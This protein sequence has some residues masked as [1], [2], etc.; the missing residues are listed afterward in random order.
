[1]PISIQ[2]FRL[3]TGIFCSIQHKII[4]KKNTLIQCG[5]QTTRSKMKNNIHFENLTTKSKEPVKGNTASICTYYTSLWCLQIYLFKTKDIFFSQKCTETKNKVI[6]KCNNSQILI[7]PNTFTKQLLN[8][9]QYLLNICSIMLC[10][11]FLCYM[12]LILLLSNDI[13]TNPG[14]NIKNVSTNTTYKHVICGNIHQGSLRYVQRLTS[15]SSCMTNSITSLAFTFLKNVTKWSNLDI[16][17][18]IEHGID[19]YEK[20]YPNRHIKDESSYL[21]VNDLNTS[22]AINKNYFTCNIHSSILGNLEANFQDPNRIFSNLEE[23]LKSSFAVSNKCIFIL[24][25]YGMSVFRSSNSF[26]VFDP[27]S[28]NT[29]GL[30]SENGTAVCTILT[31]FSDLCKHI[32]LLGQSLI[33]KTLQSI[34]FEIT[35]IHLQIRQTPPESFYMLEPSNIH[36]LSNVPTNIKKE[37]TRNPNLLYAQN[38]DIATPSTSSKIPEFISQTKLPQ[39]RKITSTEIPH[40][41][42]SIQ[43]NKRRN[44]QCKN[45]LPE[46]TSELSTKNRSIPNS[47]LT[48]H[49]E[50]PKVQTQNVF[51]NN[52]NIFEKELIDS[53]IDSS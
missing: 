37:N 40:Y 6:T 16:D 34:Q 36:I 42:T 21:Q 2:Q 49:I 44:L 4:Q 15:S 17:N 23:S 28:R 1:M 31:N 8:T 39:K 11:S 38:L 52:K 41:V 50:Y 45:K 46:Y 27:H 22:F 7:A 14:P 32:R 30:F 13:E 48:T 12:Y 3:N 20:L 33:N 5:C 35:P 25:E 43:S 19:F 29:E 51:N 10:T 24:E 26:C 53:S 18:I 47:Q 9:K